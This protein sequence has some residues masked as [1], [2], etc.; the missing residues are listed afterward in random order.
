MLYIRRFLNKIG[1]LFE[2][3]RFRTEL[4]EELAVH[5]ALKHREHVATGLPSVEAAA[6]AR[7]DMGNAT[8][9]TDRSADER[10]FVSLD[11]LIQD[12]R[13]AFR[14]MRKNGG[15]T[16]VA[17]LSLALGIGGNTAVFSLL[18]A[19]L[20]K[21]LPFAHPERLV[22]I[23][24]FF[25]KAL[26]V[27][28]RQQ[29][30]TM[31]LASTST[32]V[33]LNVTG[34]GPAFRITASP[35][36]ANLFSLLGAPVELG[37]S[38]DE[39]DDVPGRDR[40]AILSHDLWVEQFHSD[41]S[42][43]GRLI[44]VDGVE[45][46]IVGVMTAGFA[47]P[48]ARIQMWFPAAADP[49]NQTEYWAGE[50]TPLI[51]RL[52]PGVSMDQ[53]ASEIR[54]LAADV[55]Q[56]FPW[57]MPRH[58]NANATVIPLQTD[59][60]G[61]SR[62]RLLMLLCTVGAVL[63]IAC[64][65]VAGLLTARGAARSKEMAMRAALGAGRLRIVRQLLTESVV[66]ATAAGAVGLALGA[67]A[68]RLFNGVLPPDLPGA[69][70]VEIDWTVTAFTLGLSVLAGISF[71]VAPAVRASR[72][73][74]LAAVK[75]GGQRSATTGST[76]FRSWLV[77]GEVG[78]T[79]V[80]VVCAALLVRSVLALSRVNPGFDPRSVLAVKISPDASVCSKPAACVAFYDRLTNESRSV[81]GVTDVALANTVPLDGSAPSLAVDVEDHPKTAEFPAP[82]FWTGA[83]SPEYLRLMGIALLAGRTLTQADTAASEP[84]LLVSASTARRF[85]P[86]QS[87]IGKHVKW[88]AEKQWRTV[89]GVVADVRQYSLADR[90]PA[91]I[92]GAMYMPYAQSIDGGGRI[93]YVMNLIVRASAY[94]PNTSVEL[95]QFAVALNPNV[96]VGRVIELDQLVGESVASFRSTTWLLLSFASVALVLAAIGIYGLVSYSVTQ[97]TY[98]IALRMAIG[99]TGVGI[100]RMILVRSIRLGLVGLLAGLLASFVAV[101]GISV[102][103]FGVAPTDPA[104]FVLVS[105]FLMAVTIL[106][107]LIPAWHASRVDPVRALRAE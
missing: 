69:A 2:R 21:P 9:A 60:A 79:L 40:L 84:V 25:P 31:D 36:S 55:W 19:I 34:Q 44:T 13:H 67:S 11:Q 104:T 52:R 78:L 88:V 35:V 43:V 63:V 68:L 4:A 30:R 64:A 74:I 3:E 28:F 37:Q 38:F 1:F 24:E 49:R 62:G 86:G 102:M 105:V 54:S 82:M 77:A 46:R 59:L 106:A 97:R 42:A 6:Q 16:T 22:R 17:I 70:Q 92:S 39:N 107:S 51:G 20:I 15:F 71:G 103:L 93:P 98:E 45:R 26:L 72:L 48:S 5:Q 83:V 32:G 75:A 95:R 7:V 66:L 58:W 85:W 50:F 12:V 29:C 61:D 14:V 23:T 76:R 94:H 89:I 99:A 90:V 33:E 87:A 91:G 56:M 101:R 8:L 96:P 41:P 65:N 80:L 73:N 81:R 53:A 100:L 47:F 18:N 27:H 10:T 57:P